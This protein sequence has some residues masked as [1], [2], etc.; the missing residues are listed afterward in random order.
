MLKDK[1]FYDQIVELLRKRNYYDDNV[2]SFGF[3]HNDGRS[4]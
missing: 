4:I 3:Y 1:A 2:W